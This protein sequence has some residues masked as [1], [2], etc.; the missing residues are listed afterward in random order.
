[1]SALRRRLGG[2]KDGW[3]MIT[4]T[5]GFDSFKIGSG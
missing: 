1:V 2:R 3:V 4:V 5:A